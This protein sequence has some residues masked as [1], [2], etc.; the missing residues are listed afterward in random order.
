MTPLWLCRLLWLLWLRHGKLQARNLL[1]CKCNWNRHSY[2]EGC[3][4]DSIPGQSTM[5]VHRPCRISG[6]QSSVSQHGGLGKK[7][8]NFWW[9][10]HRWS[11]IFPQNFRFPLANITPLKSHNNLLSRIGTRKPITVAVQFK[12]WNFFARSNAGISFRIPLKAWMSL[13]VYSVFVLSRVQVA[14]LR[15]ADPLS[16]EAYRLSNIKKLKWKE[17][18]HECPMFQSGRKR[19]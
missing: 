3:D 1:I 14:A 7:P 4:Q 6:C 11:K 13:C 9:T 8:L 18:F 17:T 5:G 12:A 16:K 10:M 2:I 19:R 15:L